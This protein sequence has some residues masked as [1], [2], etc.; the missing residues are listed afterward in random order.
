[1]GRLRVMPFVMHII[2]YPLVSAKGTLGFR[3]L[4]LGLHYSTTP[5]RYSSLLMA[6]TSWSCA[7]SS[8]ARRGRAHSLP[9]TT[10]SSS[11]C[12]RR[13]ALSMRDSMTHGRYLQPVL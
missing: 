9:A 10:S 7:H 3:L 4:K 8:N 11:W 2:R 1:M 5:G 12:S 13:R 6:V